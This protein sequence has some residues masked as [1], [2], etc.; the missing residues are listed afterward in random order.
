MVTASSSIVTTVAGTGLASYSGNG[1]QATTAML[2][3]LIIVTLDTF[4]NIYIAD[5][6]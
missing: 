2:R 3:Y 4:G 5:A 6:G 1:E